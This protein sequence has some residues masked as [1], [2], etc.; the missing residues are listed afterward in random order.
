MLKVQAFLYHQ[1][2][3]MKKALVASFRVEYRI[4]KTSRLQ[5]QKILLVGIK[6]VKIFIGEK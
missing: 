3:L 6:I 2:V 5:L 1:R 4:A